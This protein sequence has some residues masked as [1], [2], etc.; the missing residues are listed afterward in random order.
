[1]LMYYILMCQISLWVIRVD[2]ISLMFMLRLISFDILEFSLPFMHF[3]NLTSN[4]WGQTKLASSIG[5]DTQAS[6]ILT[7]SPSPV[8]KL[9][10]GRPNPVCAPCGT[11]VFGH[12]ELCGKSLGCAPISWVSFYRGAPAAFGEQKWV[13]FKSKD[14]AVYLVGHREPAPV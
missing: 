13:M 6:A 10:S 4:R 2:L 3:W 11:S 9:G 1:M 14:V 7:L 8:G 12:Q 5:P